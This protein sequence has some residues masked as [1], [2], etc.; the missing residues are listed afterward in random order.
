MRKSKGETPDKGEM[1]DTKLPT[2]CKKWTKLQ[3]HHKAPHFE[4]LFALPL[5][6]AFISSSSLETQKLGLAK[7]Y[8]QNGVKN[9]IW[10]I[11]RITQK[12]NRTLTKLPI[13]KM[14]PFSFLFLAFGLRITHIF[15]GANT[16]YP[17]YVSN[18]NLFSLRGLSLKYFT[19]TK[20]QAQ[21]HFFF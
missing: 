14:L 11:T 15:S 4:V 20:I 9:A 2:E 8:K 1:V 17:V 10:M 7:P 12:K 19:S 5:T 16:S 18:P 6:D 3:T 13:I 21:F